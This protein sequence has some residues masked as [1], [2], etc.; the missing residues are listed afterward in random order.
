MATAFLAAVDTALLVKD[1][2]RVGSGMHQGGQFSST[3]EGTPSQQA[4]ATIAAYNQSGGLAGRALPVARPAAAPPA[5]QPAA[6]PTGLPVAKPAA[7]SAALPTGPAPKKPKPAKAPKAPKPA[8]APKAPKPPPTPKPAAPPPAARPAAPPPTPKPAKAPKPPKP[9]KPAK[10][11][12]ASTRAKT[13]PE[14]KAQAAGLRNKAHAL[15]AQAH[16]IDLKIDAL[17][18]APSTKP[19]KTSTKSK[20][21]AKLE[22]QAGVLRRQATALLG[23]AKA[24]LRSGKKAAA[25]ELVKAG[26]GGPKE[27][28]PPGG[29]G[30]QPDWPGWQHDQALTAIYAAKLAAAFKTAMSKVKDMV[31]QWMRGTL[32]V[33]PAG[34]ADQIRDEV[35]TAV[36]KVLP[37]ALTEGYALGDAA[38][39][40]VLRP[41]P[42]DW[43]AWVPGDVEA[44]RKVAD[45]EGLQNLLSSYGVRAV[46]SIADGKMDDLAE[47]ISGAVARG[48]SADALAGD[49]AD[50][51][52]DADRAGM[53]AH[54]EI[55]RA[56][57]SAAMDRYNRAGVT[58]KR[59]LTAP[60]ACTVCLDN[61][62]AGPILM[63]QDFPGGVQTS[64]Q[65]PVC[66]CAVAP[67][68]LG[69]VTFAVVPDLTKDAA[70][71]TDPNPVEPEHVANLMRKNFPEKAIKWV[72]DARWVGP[73]LIPQ[74][75]IDCDDEDSWAA[76]HEPEA[77]A[78]FAKD[79]K[80]GTG[81][82]HPVI[83]VQTSDDDKADIVDGHHRTLAYR[84]LGQPVKA[85]VGFV[86][87]GDD[88][89]QETHSSQLNQGGSPANKAAEGNAETLREYWSGQSHGGPTHFAGAKE[90]A[91]GTPGD[92]DRCV[93]LAGKYMADEQAAGYCNLRHHEALGYWPS[94]HAAR[95]R[96]K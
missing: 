60:G 77:V 85:Y 14:A 63:D 91:W 62:G 31:G 53:I 76:S 52:G 20:Q 9:A 17:R 96:G 84:K 26:D 67:A 15:I 94:Q 33:T 21:I 59:W 42:A 41:G 55:A 40:A 11:A 81:H 32:P 24:T 1:E 4:E 79:I 71:L 88:R 36:G 72:Y 3:G 48:D 69:G 61:E 66:R 87:A 39:T 80:N 2:Q 86:P 65:H 46:Q 74:D 38:A 45:A 5:A 43:G 93:T 13:S 92:F 90:I 7:Q 22:H 95:E 64:P 19:R 18:A 50:L 6:L 8:K 29:G 82:T 23:Q 51:V 68:A 37:D 57:S 34:L 35:T 30:Q 54:T 89:W 49:I 16:Q 56:V 44:A 83:M 78:R 73:V 70:D 12:K 75:R 27:Q 28:T 47:A 25:A 10:P 58:Q